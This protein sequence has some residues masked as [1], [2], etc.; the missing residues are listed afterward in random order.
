MLR[1]IDPFIAT[2]LLAVLLASFLPARGAVGDGLSQAVSVSVAWLFFLYG[3]RLPAREALAALGQWRLHASV[4]TATFV[5]FPVLGLAAQLLAPAVLPT[6]LAQGLLF[7]SVLPSTV[8]S[9]ITFT[10]IAGGNVAGAICAASFSNLAGVFLTPV[11]VALMLGGTLGL[12]VGLVGK[13]A[14]QLLL[15]FV[16]GQLARRWLAA[17]MSRHRR[18][19]TLSERGAIVLTVYVAFSH[20]VVDG[21]WSTVSAGALAVLVGSCS[22]MLAIVLAVT[23][24]AGRRLGMSRPDQVVLLMCGSKKSLA[25]GVPLATV[26][27]PAA[28]IGVTVLPLMIFHQIQLIVCAVIARRLGQDSGGRPATAE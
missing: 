13:V 11:L 16:V 24:S 6:G 20:A 4:L 21:I 8:Q 15:P 7:L 3:L 25:S 14:L 23:Y 28:M 19:T 12:S 17:R 10:S 22:L 26:L 27:L 18:I 1:R 5:L 2:L 9:S